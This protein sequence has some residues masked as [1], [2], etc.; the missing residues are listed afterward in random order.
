MLLALRRHHISFVFKKGTLRDTFP[1]KLY[2]G[3]QCEVWLPNFHQPALD[4]CEEMKYKMLNELGVTD[5]PEATLV[6][7][8]STIYSPFL[9]NTGKAFVSFHRKQIYV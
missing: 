8:D 2:V 4:T 1:V 5:V 9:F 3:W 6:D 7:T